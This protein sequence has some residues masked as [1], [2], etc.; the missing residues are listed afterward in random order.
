[1]Q[2]SSTLRSSFDGAT[3]PG[4]AQAEA[5]G[6]MSHVAPVHESCMRCALKMDGYAIASAGAVFRRH[7]TGLQFMPR[8]ACQ[9]ALLVVGDSVGGRG[10][11]VVVSNETGAEGGAT[12][13]TLMDTATGESLPGL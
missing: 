12:C 11:C 1:M 8:R 10:W 4:A 13:R 5:G 2:S 6:A 3:A 7:Q 9:T